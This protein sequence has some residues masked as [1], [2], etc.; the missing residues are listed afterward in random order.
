MYLHWN[1]IGTRTWKHGTLRAILIRAYK[2]C[3]TEKLLQNE[4]KLIEEEL[5]TQTAIQKGYLAK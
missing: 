4:L 5:L 1:S 2:V 3:S